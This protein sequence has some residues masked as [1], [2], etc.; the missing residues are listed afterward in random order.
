M[1]GI[2][3]GLTWVGARDACA[4]KN[5]FK[6]ISDLVL[7]ASWKREGS[8][9]ISKVGLLNRIEVGSLGYLVTNLVTNLVKNLVIH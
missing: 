8:D 9:I 7:S 5:K 6:F 1:D 2:T 4:S 3:D